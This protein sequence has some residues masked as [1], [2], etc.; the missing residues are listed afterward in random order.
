MKP[1]RISEPDLTTWIA[2]RSGELWAGALDVVEDM[3][4]VKNFDGSF[5][6][7]NAAYL[8]FLGK[9]REA[10]RGGRSDFDLFP[11]DE[12]EGFFAHDTRLLESEQP[13]VSAHSAR[14]HEQRAVIDVAVKSVVRGPVDE[15]LGLIGI[16]KW[17]RVGDDRVA[18]R[19]EVKAIVRRLLPEG[20]AVSQLT[21]LDQSVAALLS[22]R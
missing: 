10:V 9:S 18:C 15:V 13:V 20:I 1:L 2:S 7:N 6:Y 19:T 3:V 12:A 21:A 22:A 16:V 4:F 14:D 17:V 8:A 5:L 11:A